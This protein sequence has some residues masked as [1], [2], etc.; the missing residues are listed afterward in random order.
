MKSTPPAQ[1]PAIRRKANM[2]IDRQ[3]LIDAGFD[4]SDV[5]PGWERHFESCWLR[6]H[7]GKVYIGRPDDAEETLVNEDVTTQ[8]GL[9]AIV[10]K[11]E[12]STQAT[13]RK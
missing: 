4:W 9:L 1:N 6:W 7:D 8:A 12:V 2:N 5:S 10:A 11:M 13:V 3:F